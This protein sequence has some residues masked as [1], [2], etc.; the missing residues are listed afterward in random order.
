MPD[1]SDYELAAI[2]YCA[3]RGIP[4]ST[5]LNVWSED[6]QRAALEWAAEQARTCAGC[7][8]NLEE[9]TGPGAF[10]TWNAEIAGHCD[11]CRARARKEAELSG[12]DD[13]DPHAGV[14]LR[15]WKDEVTDG[16]VHQPGAAG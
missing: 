9:T 12:S 4:L 14:R 6:D 7:G 3:P 15:L 1:R 5:F 11:G 13:L 16:R 10:D 8:Q 2:E